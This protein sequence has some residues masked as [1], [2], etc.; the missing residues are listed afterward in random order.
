MRGNFLLVVAI[1]V[2][3]DYGGPLRQ[4]PVVAR[5]FMDLNSNDHH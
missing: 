1:S 4:N 3:I 5:P 2:R